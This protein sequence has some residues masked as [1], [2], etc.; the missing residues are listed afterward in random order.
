MEYFLSNEKISV[1]MSEKEI[2]PGSRW[3]L[4]IKNA[5][6]NSKMMCI[7]TTPSSIK[8]EWVTTEWAVAWAKNIRV[9]PILLHCSAEDLPERL[10]DYQAI[11][12][13]EMSKIVELLREQSK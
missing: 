12:F 9:V 7:L 10:R 4:D 6:S 8:S 1:F 3:E 5:L 11:D 2:K 13:H